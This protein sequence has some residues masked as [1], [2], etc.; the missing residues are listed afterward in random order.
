MRDEV[1]LDSSIWIELERRNEEIKDLV[2]PYIK[3]NR[4]FLV[5]VI[6]AEVLRGVRTRKDFL[7][8]QRAFSDFVCLSTSWA[9]VSELAFQVARAG[10]W[11]PLIDLY[12]AQ[13]SLDYK[14][15]I[16]T[17]DTDFEHIAKVCPLELVVC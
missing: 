13:C 17:K 5:D 2:D 6:I 7:K 14:I 11:P 12:I 8:L 10:Y 9:K 16:I 3:Q 1:I 4:V 15:T